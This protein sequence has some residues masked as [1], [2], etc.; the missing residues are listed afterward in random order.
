LVSVV[1]F[2]ADDTLWDFQGAMRAALHAML[3]EL[4]TAFPGRES[5]GLTVDRMIAI[6]DRVAV[7]LEG[8]VMDLAV[9]RMASFERALEEVGIVEAGL[10]AELGASYFSH[11]VHFLRLFDDT[12]PALD[13]LAGWRLGVVSNGN[14]DVV[15]LGIADRFETVVRSVDVGVGKPDPAIIEFALERFG[16][17]PDE[18]VLVGDSEEADVKAARAAG[19]QSVLLDRHGRSVGSEAD[20]VIGSLTELPALVAQSA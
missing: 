2:D 12:L 14:A 1:L 10:A 17:T 3:E 5:A 19:I 11:Q 4:W 18:A 7:E 8:R 6:R 20:W 13:A 9:I 15:R 16:V